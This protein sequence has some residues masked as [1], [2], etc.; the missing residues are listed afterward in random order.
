MP[1]IDPM[2]KD[3]L[4]HLIPGRIAPAR[5]VPSHIVRP[6][7]IGKAAPDPFTGSDVKNAD[8]IGRESPPMNSM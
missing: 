8:T 3:S 5:R 6:P 7:Y 4:G 1:R 2:P